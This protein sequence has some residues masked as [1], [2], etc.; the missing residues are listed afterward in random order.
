MTKNK[1]TKPSHEDAEETASRSKAGSRGR[2]AKS[3]RK[4]SEN[5]STKPNRKL[6][7]RLQDLESQVE[8]LTADIKRER[9]DFMNYKRRSEAER[10]QVTESAKTE[11][12][13]QLLPVFD[14]LERALSSPPEAIAE[15]SWV[16]GIAQVYRQVQNKLSELG[17][18]RIECLGTEFDPRLHEAVGYDEGKG[19][20]EVITEELRPGY[21]LG[22]TVLRPSM[23]KVGKT[24]SDR[25]EQS[26]EEEE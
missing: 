16:K 17:V 18:E 11:I 7:K 4:T 12:I 1:Q 3:G 23:V 13:S 2:G 26:A 21:Q 19:D 10:L 6:E 5:G 22:D 9:A 25:A 24:S 14:D 20:K 15:D 8:Q